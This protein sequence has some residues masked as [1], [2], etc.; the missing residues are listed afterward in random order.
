M[1][2]QTL[3]IDWKYAVLVVSAVVVLAILSGGYGYFFGRYEQI[4]I[5]KSVLKAIPEVNCETHN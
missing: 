3:Q 1:Q 2:Q 4:A 5:N